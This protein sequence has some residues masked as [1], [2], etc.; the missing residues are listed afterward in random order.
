MM[1]I[2]AIIS[3]LLV[4]ILSF[5]PVMAERNEQSAY[6]DIM[7]NYAANLYIDDSTDAYD[8]LMTAVEDAVKDNPE[9]MYQF[10]KTA[11]SSLDEY[12]EF[13]TAEEYAKVYQ[14]LNDV[15]YGIGVVV[16][17]V[18]ND[19]KIISVNEGGG[20]DDAA[21]FAGDIIIKVDGKS[22]S[23]LNLDE[24][25]SMIAG[26]EGTLVKITVL[27]NNK[28]ITFNV[29]RKKVNQAT[30]NY[31]ILKGDIGYLIISSFSELTPTEVKEALLKFDEHNI[32]NIILD[33][34]YNPG[35]HLMSVV[36][37]AKLFVPKGPI[38]HAV[39]RG[40]ENQTFYSD[41]LNPE[42]K[43]AVLVNGDTASAA[44]VLASALQ[45]SG[46]GYLIGRTTYGK[47]LIQDVFNLKNGDAFKITTGHYL[48]RNGHDINKV[49]IEPDEVVI[50]HTERPDPNEYTKFCYK[51]K[52]K[53]GETG[54]GV[55]A[56]K[57]RLKIMGYYKG[58][59]NKYFDKSLEKAVYN[60]QRDQGLYPYGVIDFSTQ[61]TIENVFIRYDIEIDDQFE[62]AYTYFGGKLDEE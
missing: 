18:D 27:R 22:V 40:S 6:L 53:V 45:D 2:K 1:K 56:A 55:L 61:A 16:Q 20:A 23:G 48:T 35:G 28:E 50:N 36:E 29:T 39:F 42:Y 5:S 11:F 54:D 8:L 62:M 30:V 14:N 7:L 24:V 31:A 52:W 12:T 41:N 51:H 13:Y 25:V 43:F 44:E 60:F 26:D 4:F 21:I 17:K 59:L 37:V 57:E 47:G 58:E 32:K 19:I 34:R 15:F 46:A 38:V 49:G 33:L 10:I 3:L 9:L